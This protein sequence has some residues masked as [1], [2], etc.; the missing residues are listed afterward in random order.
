MSR[1]VRLNVPRLEKPTSMQTSVTSVGRAEQIHR[2]LD[3]TTLE[4]AMRRLAEGRLEGADEMRLRHARD[5]RQLTDRERLAVA[6]V[7]GVAGPEQATV[8]VL[9]VSH[10]PQS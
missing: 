10:H 3:A 8:G 6:P 1:N 4:I 7:D 5:R 2:P 9:D